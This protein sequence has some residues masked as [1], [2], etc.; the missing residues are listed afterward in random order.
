VNSRYPAPPFD[1]ELQPVLAQMGE[2]IPSSM[3][4]QRLL[5]VRSTPRPTRAQALVASGD[6]LREDR[7]VPGLG[8]DPE[9]ELSVFKKPAHVPGSPVVYYIHGGGMVNGD[10]TLIDVVLPWIELFNL[11]VV[12][13][14]YRL[15]P[16][17]PDPA[18][19]RDCYAGLIWTAAQA[20]ELGADADHLVIAGMSAGGG[21]A[22]GIA[23]MARDNH[24][25]DVAAQILICPML[26]DRNQTISSQQIQGIGVWDRASNETGWTAL[27]G[28]RRGTDEVSIC[29]A[30]ARA[31]DLS[32]LPPAYV[33][34]G[35]AEVFRDEAV[36][37]ASAIWAA[38]GVADLHVWAGG[39]HGFDMAAP[40]AL[41]SVAA[42][43]T[44]ADFLR[45]IL[46]L[47][48]EAAATGATGRG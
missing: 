40:D 21:L 36:A 28:D 9:I 30:P 2:T 16:E 45:I 11:V 33:D 23:L 24:T 38:G 19:V 41:V 29:A 32:G 7:C 13:V 1:A 5:Q 44:R 34:C 42:G 17:H 25:P 31:S 37:Y 8:D 12:S 15:A 43:R 35:S 47:P 48:A 22:A 26:D 20:E 4:L 14:E 39:F 46:G 6:L 10:R 3:D 18:P 27:L